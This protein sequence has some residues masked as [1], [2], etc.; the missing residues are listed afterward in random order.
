MSAKN[1]SRVQSGGLQWEINRPQR[2]PHKQK[3]EVPFSGFGCVS[4]C[5]LNGNWERHVTAVFAAFVA[6]AT[7][8][9][10]TSVSQGKRAQRH[11]G[12]AGL[13]GTWV[14][15]WWTAVGRRRR[16]AE[17]PPAAAPPTGARAAGVPC[18]RGLADL[19]RSRP[20]LTAHAPRAAGCAPL[21]A[22]RALPSRW[23]PSRSC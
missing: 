21:A 12:S 9:P 7:R 14:L 18:G 20:A 1:D 8:E 4:H 11:R 23:C 3:G 17:S 22:A 19:P 16:P 5:R 10:S 15:P 2:L 6:Q 13:G